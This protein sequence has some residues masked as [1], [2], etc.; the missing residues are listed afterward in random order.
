VGLRRGGR[1]LLLDPG[2]YLYSEGDGWRRHFRGSA[3]HSCVVIDGRDQADVGSE[4]FGIGPVAPAAW[5][6]FAGDAG[7]AAFEAEHPAH[8]E[9]RVRR[10]AVWVRGGTLLL[11]D[12][13]LGSGRHDLEVWLQLPASSG[14]AEGVST[15][16]RLPEGER[17]RVRGLAGVTALRLERPDP[18]AG[19]APGWYSPRYGVRE[20][21]TALRLCS[22]PVE[23]PHRMVTL[24]EVEGGTSLHLA[25]AAGGGLE[26]TWPGGSLSLPPDGGFRGPGV[27]APG[28]GSRRWLASA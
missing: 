10:R 18:G 27:P 28:A 4:R 22:G 26:L 19:P 23:L 1:D 17:L 14:S 9:P 15:L 8:G 12:E 25:E 24:V 2:T 7:S 16:L 20:V 11:C 13:V 6:F 3:A 21:G 5:R